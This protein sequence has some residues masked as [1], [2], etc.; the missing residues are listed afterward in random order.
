LAKTKQKKENT[1]MG[2]ELYMKVGRVS[3]IAALQNEQGQHYFRE[4]CSIDMSKCGESNVGSLASDYMTKGKAMLY[5][6]ENDKEVTEDACGDRPMPIPTRLV[7]EALRK[8]VKVLDHGDNDRPYRRFE[9]A[10]SLLEAIEKR[11]DGEKKEFCVIFE[12]H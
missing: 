2:Y 6:Y 4:D 3:E 9:W 5:W 7:I 12:G 11:D 8:D 1:N 10:L